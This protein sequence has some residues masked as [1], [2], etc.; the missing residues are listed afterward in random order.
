[1]STLL[2]GEPVFFV[3]LR[4]PPQTSKPAAVPATPAVAAATAALAAARANMQAFLAATGGGPGVIVTND[5]AEVRGYL[6]ARRRLRLAQAAY[7]RALAEARKHVRP[8]VPEPAPAPVDLSSYVLSLEYEEDEK[9]ADELT[10]TLRNDDL[11]FFDTP[12]FEAGT[13]LLVG[14]GYAGALAPMREVVVQKITGSTT[15][16]VTARA[17]SVLLHTKTRV[18]TFEN[19]TRSEVVRLIAEEHGYGKAQQDIEDTSVRHAVLSQAALTDAQFLKRLA[20]QEGFEFYVDF[21]G[22]HW[23]RRRFG[24]KPVRVLSYYLP[25]N[26]GDIKSFSLEKDITAKPGAVTVKGRNPVTK[27][28]VTVTADNAATKRETLAPVIEVVDPTTG[29]KTRKTR[30]VASEETRPTSE[31]NAASAKAEADAIFRRTQQTAVEITL[32]LVGDPY[33]VAKTVVELRGFG[34]R[35]SGKYYV[36]NI[37]HTL[38]PSGYSMRA[39]VRTDG[40]Q[41]GAAKAKGAANTKAADAATA[42]GALTPIAVIDPV[43]GEKRTVYRDTRGRAAG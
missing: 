16:K 5:D 27:Q 19:R 15:L 30:V 28:T 29:E 41:Q 31:T 37:K 35:L 20:D 17:K 33:L 13:A 11:S 9:K 42:S 2:R 32:E 14:W 4:P 39:K 6:E 10:L 8:A 1:M 3:R 23:H 21:D 26:V 18:R 7:D 12:L 34:K 24:Q 25:P 36:A 38:N 43:T 40:T 22:L